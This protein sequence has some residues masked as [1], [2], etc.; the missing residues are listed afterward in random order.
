MDIATFG[1]HR[2][3]QQNRPICRHFCRA[4][5]RTRTVNPLLAMVSTQA[6]HSAA[7]IPDSPSSS[8]RDRDHQ[9]PARLPLSPGRA[10]LRL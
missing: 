10:S 3:G 8:C 9:G 7:A 6:I 2:D 4:L 5:W 1:R